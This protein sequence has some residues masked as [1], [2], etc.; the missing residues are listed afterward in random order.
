MLRIRKKTVQGAALTY[1]NHNKKLADFWYCKLGIIRK[2]KKK[3]KKT[4]KKQKKSFIS[5][6]LF[7][8]KTLDLEISVMFVTEKLHFLP[9]SNL[10]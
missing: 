2:T 4:L 3:T 6:F 5:E 1:I 9:S 8:D 10:Y 7:P